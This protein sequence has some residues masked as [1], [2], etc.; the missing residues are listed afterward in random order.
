MAKSSKRT[1]KTCEEATLKG[2][3]KS[4]CSPASVD[5]HTHCSSQ[6]GPVVDLFG[7]VLVP[8]S[9]SAQQESDKAKTTKDISGRRCSV[10]SKSV[11]LQ[12]SLASRLAE[13]S[14]SHGSMEYSLTWSRKAT[15]AG[16][17]I[18]RLRASARRK[19][20]SDCSGWPAP[21]VNDSRGG[22]NKTASRSRADSQHHDGVTLVDAADLIGW[23]APLATDGS[24]APTKYGKDGK[25]GLALSGAVKLVGWACP[26]A[27]DYKSEEATEEFNTERDSH[28]RGKPLSYQVTGMTP[29]SSNAETGSRDGYRLNPAFSLWLQ[30]YPA[31]WA[32]CGELA[33]QSCRK[34]RRCS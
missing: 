14:A 31:A 1:S 30:G 13:N 11:D 5:G 15:P 8:V 4:T 25:N 24:K 18:F 27:R 33:M 32:S 7:Q 2:S 22:R 19:S 26:S 3:S 23:P 28:P 21:T 34:S 20:D 6:D 12:Q 29:K 9:R 17:R 10:S 16:R